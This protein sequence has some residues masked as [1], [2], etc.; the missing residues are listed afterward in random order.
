MSNIINLGYIYVY[1]DFIGLK[2]LTRQWRTFNE[3]NDMVE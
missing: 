1:F 2:I 3:R